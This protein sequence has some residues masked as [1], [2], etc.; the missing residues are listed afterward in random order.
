MAASIV[1]FG[2]AL[3]LEYVPA[4]KVDVGDVVDAASPAGRVRRIPAA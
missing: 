4:K 2:P 1:A 3:V